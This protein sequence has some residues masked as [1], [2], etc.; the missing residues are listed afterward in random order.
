MTDIRIEV[1]Q[2][3]KAL[4]EAKALEQADWFYA[5]RLVDILITNGLQ[6]DLIKRFE[7]PDG[8]GLN[9]LKNYES[10]RLAIQALAV[11]GLS[12]VVRIGCETVHAELA[13][14]LATTE[15]N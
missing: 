9:N 6:D 7:H 12:R 2:A 4:G 10:L 13:S 14:Q 15:N 5:N 11:F 1:E 3:S 8:S